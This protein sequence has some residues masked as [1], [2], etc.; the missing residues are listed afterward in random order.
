MNFTGKLDI[1]KIDRSYRLTEDQYRKEVH[2]KTQQTFHFSAG[3]DNARGMFMGWQADKRKVATA[4][5]IIDNGVLCEAFDPK[6]AANG[7]GYWFTDNF[8]KVVGGNE[9]AYQ[10]CPGTDNGITNRKI[11]DRNIQYEVCN[12]GGLTFKDGKYHTWASTLKNPI[13][14]PESKIITYEK[15]FRGLI[16]YEKI[17]DEELETLW[18]AFRYNCAMFNIPAKFDVSNFDLNVNA[19]MG[20]PGIYVHSNFRADKGDWPPDPRLIE[21]LK[22]L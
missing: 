16:H 10:L 21:M 2:E 3:W 22:A 14:L 12:W 18:K 13:V 6:Y 20:V 9:K 11:E 15:P 17:T 7:I 1:T 4:Y 19:I 5:G 8:G